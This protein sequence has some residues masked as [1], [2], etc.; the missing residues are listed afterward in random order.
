MLASEIE[1]PNLCGASVKSFAATHKHA[2]SASDRKDRRRRTLGVHALGFGNV[3]VCP[4]I[5]FPYRTTNKISDT[6]RMARQ[7]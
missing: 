5:T 4:V 3:T 6:A 7:A 1:S 2:D